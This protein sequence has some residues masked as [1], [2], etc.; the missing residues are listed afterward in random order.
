MTALLLLL[1]FGLAVIG[2]IVAARVLEGQ[3]W[4]SSL[5]A[6]RLRLPAHVTVD[7]IAAWLG[8]VQVMTQSPPWALIQNPPV[9]LEVVADSQ[10]IAV[11]MLAPRALRASML[12]SLQAALPTVRVDEAPDYL[13]TRP[14]FTIGV[15]STLTD[16][17]RPLSTEQASSTSQHILAALSSL[18]GSERICLQWIFSAAH[19]P[20]PRVVVKG[21][22]QDSLL[23]LLSSEVLA[24][25]EAIQAQKKKLRSALLLASF[26][27]GVAGSNRAAALGVLR[28]VWPTFKG[29]DAPGVRLVRRYWLPYRVVADRISGL[30]LP[31]MRYPLLL[32]VDEAAGLV[33]LAPGGLHLPGLARGTARTLPASPNVPSR[34]LVIA[35]TNYPGQARPLALSRLDRLRHVWVVGPTGSGKSTL[36]QNLIEQDM[37]AGDGLLVVDARGD[38]VAD[39]LD[40]VP[41]SRLNDVVILDASDVTRVVGYNPLGLGH[42]E[43]SRELAAEHVL[44]VMHAVFRASWGQRTEDV[45]RASLLTMVHT[46]AVGG[47]RLTLAE[48]PELLTNDAFRLFVLRQGLPAHL[49][50]FWQW[51]QALSEAERM[52]VIAPVLNKL[53]SFTLSTP[54]RLTLGQSD[55]IDLSEVF[56]RQRIVLVPLKKGLLGSETTALIGSLVVAGMWQA[57]LARANTPREHRR[58]A[59]LYADEF[60]EVTRMSLDVADMLAQARGLGLGLTLAHQYIGQLTPELR[61]A[62]M[63]S[64]RTQIAF[65][66]D[67]DDAKTL[68]SRFM[69]LTAEDLANLDAHEIAIRPSVGG[70]TQSPITGVTYPPSE[71][72]GSRAAVLAA[73]G[74]RFGLLRSDIEAGLADRITL[75]PSTT[76]RSNRR[77]K[78][79]S[80]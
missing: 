68:A 7:D 67:H 22:E 63:G 29:M 69:P 10:R 47:S 40:R 72:L 78:G 36:L 12:A 54:L 70:M 45:L 9:A 71:P 6:L 55:G 1:M 46:R 66:S 42:D 65:Q 80:T 19:R 52:S 15:E 49:A 75:S 76:P 5:V 58:P 64:T 51:Y 25:N 27:V 59:W 17:A 74:K 21:H 16:G 62:V 33:A 23:A 48:L 61:A 57:A 50:G 31:A 13:S 39:L 28:R 34:G 56:A 32:N 20:K 4:R 30:R 53:R 37:R 38:L 73:S 43:R 24:T 2:V 77:A 8:R 60:Q 18:D 79:G 41:E 3:S 44:S 11:Y 14:R 35:E 26:R